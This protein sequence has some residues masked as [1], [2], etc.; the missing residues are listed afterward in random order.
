VNYFPETSRIEIRSPET[1]PGVQEYT[2]NT[3]K[4]AQGVQ[5]Y[6]PNTRK[7]AQG[8]QKFN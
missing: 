8:V 3:R 2:P 4:P 6:T 7:P 5:K 1:S